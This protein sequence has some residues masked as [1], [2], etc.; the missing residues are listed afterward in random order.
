MSGKSG[1]ISGR[2]SAGAGKA[3]TRLWQRTAR[4]IALEAD[5][6]GLT[7]R[8]AR[9]VAEA[10][11][12]RVRAPEALSQEERT[13]LKTAEGALVALGDRRAG[14]RKFSVASGN[15][16][17]IGAMISQALPHASI[18]P[19]DLDA[20]P[21]LFNCQNVTLRLSRILDPDDPGDVSPNFRLWCEPLPH[22]RRHHITKMAPVAYDPHATC[23]RW[24]EF[25]LR[26]QPNEAM[27]KFIQTYHG[28]ALTGLT[29]QQCFIYNYGSGA[30]GKST[31][32]EAIAALMGDYSDMLNAE[33]ITGQG[34]RRGDQATPDFAELPGVRYLRI[35]ELPRGEDLK[36][37]LVK[38]L[39]GGEEIKARHLNKGFFKFVPCFKAAMSGNDLP[40]IGGTD[41]GIWRRVRVVLWSVTIPDDQ[42]RPMNEIL[43][44][45]QE[46]RAGILNWLLQGLDFYMK[47]GLQTPPEVTEATSDYRR[48]MDPIAAFLEACVAEEPGHIETART[49]YEAFVAWC[50]ANAIRPWKETM[51]GR[52]LPN[53]G[54]V[55]ENT[56]VRRYLNVR[57]HDVPAREPPRA[58]LAGAARE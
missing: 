30:N 1:G 11:P 14:R 17:R 54:L 13:I 23:P 6:L 15:A 16:S 24:D 41:N 53:K 37:A 44:E 29:G 8:E 18:G 52:V 20:D 26:F 33:S 7:A 10:E 28:L 27:R 21:L 58:P 57:L 55:R 36:E 4:R 49:M 50:E 31:F 40:R 25:M 47:E 9:L 56:R 5:R 2:G 32:M 39:T 3:V 43:A 42:R 51:F 19:R 46:E 35:S 12:L 45:F 38:S 34:Q 22:D 48:E